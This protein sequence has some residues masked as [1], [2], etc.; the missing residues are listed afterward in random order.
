VSCGV[1]CR[2]GSDPALLW[3][4]C[5]P[6]ATASIGPLGPLAWEPPCAARVALEKAKRQKQNK[7]KQEKTNKKKNSKKQLRDLEII[8]L[9]E[10]DIRLMMAKMMQDFVKSLDAKIDNL[11]QILNKEI[12]D[13][14]LKQGEMQNTVTEIK[15]KKKYDAETGKEQHTCKFPP[16]ISY[17]SI[18][19]SKLNK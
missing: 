19:L 12:Q 18:P 15:K 10:K 6:V 17:Q 11:L 9:Q 16:P 4:W 1:G 5:R 14:K 7:T 3:L 2:R 13:L 8:N